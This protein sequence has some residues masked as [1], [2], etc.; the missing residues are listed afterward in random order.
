M[1][2]I[3]LDYTWTISWEHLAFIWPQGNVYCL[4]IYEQ[5]KDCE[6]SWSYGLYFQS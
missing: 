3:N 1:D 6:S 5:A 2:H 4:A